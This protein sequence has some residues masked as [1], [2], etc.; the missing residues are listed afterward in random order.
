[1]RIFGPAPSH[2]EAA[3]LNFGFMSSALSL[4]V[5]AYFRQHYAG[6][7]EIDASGH[8]S[9]VELPGTAFESEYLHL[10]WSDDGRHWRA[11]NDN[12]PVCDVWMRDPFVNRG[13]DGL[14]HLVAT[15]GQGKRTCLYGV[16][17]D[18][19]NWETRALP[20]MAS[21]EQANNIWAPEWFY[22]AVSGE[23][24]VFWSS[25]FADEGWKKSRLWSCRTRDWREFSAPLILFEPPYSVIDGSLWQHDGIYYLF[26]K[27]EEFGALKGERRAIRLAASDNLD[28]PWKVHDGPLNDGQIVPIITEGPAVMADPQN[29]GWLLLYDYCM[30][31]DYGVSRSDDL[32]NW[33]VEPN[34]SFPDGARHGSVVEVSQSE[35]ALIQSVHVEP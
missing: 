21:V 35:L 26:H 10:A 9:T 30:S 15:G 11:L 17:P 20:L 27:E 32:V 2:L 25:S 5:L 1:M 16:S 13:A 31:N 7:V 23:Y 29:A 6:R 8:V 3:P 34:V 12:K 4:F 22:D 18:L 19:V 33:Q 28:G 14:F 24:L